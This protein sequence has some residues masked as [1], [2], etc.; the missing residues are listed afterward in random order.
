M[1]RQIPLVLRERVC[2]KWQSSASRDGCHFFYE[3]V[4]IFERFGPLFL[5]PHMGGKNIPLSIDV[6]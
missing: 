2:M 1:I 6:G 5:P 3:R 4:F